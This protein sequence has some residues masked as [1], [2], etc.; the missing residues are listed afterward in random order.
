MRLIEDLGM[1][2]PVTQSKQKKDLGY[3][4]ALYVKITLGFAPMMLNTKG[5]RVDATNVKVSPTI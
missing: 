1:Q 2:Y 4:N 3:T 5:I